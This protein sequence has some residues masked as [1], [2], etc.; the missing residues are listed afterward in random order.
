M[1]KFGVSQRRFFFTI[2]QKC[3]QLLFR[4]LL[5]P[6]AQEGNQG[7]ACHERFSRVSRHVEISSLPSFL[8][9]SIANSRTGFCPQHTVHKAGARSLYDPLYT[10]IRRPLPFNVCR[11]RSATHR[12]LT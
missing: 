8:E 11:S 9:E 10:R 12:T 1:V 7:G 6:L 2:T 3:I 4:P 5:C